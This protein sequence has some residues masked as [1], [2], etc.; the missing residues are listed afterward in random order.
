MN[1]GNTNSNST[2][3]SSMVKAL[4]NDLYQ[5]LVNGAEPE[6]KHEQVR[7]QIYVMD[8]AHRQNPLPKRKK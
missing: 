8:E 3:F 6:I 1:H 7:R 5:V 4:Y 2:G